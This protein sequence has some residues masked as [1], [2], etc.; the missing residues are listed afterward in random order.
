MISYDKTDIKHWVNKMLDGKKIYRR[1]ASEIKRNV[2][3]VKKKSRKGDRESF[4]ADQ[5]GRFVFDDENNWF[6]NEYE[7]NGNDIVL[8]ILVNE[9]SKAEKA[10]LSFER[11]M[12]HIME[13]EVISRGYAINQLISINSDVILDTEMLL[14]SENDFN[15]KENNNSTFDE[16]IDNVVDNDNM[17]IPDD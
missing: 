2:P 10:I 3:E 4:I 7:L 9:R 6:S 17:I 1:L 16:F 8:N 14:K 5:I 15:F 13:I 11:I 12:E